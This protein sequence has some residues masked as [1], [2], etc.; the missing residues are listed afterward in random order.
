MRITGLFATL[1]LAVLVVLAACSDNDNPAGA[2]SS[3]TP[4]T[5]NEGGG[6]VDPSEAG[7]GDGG[8]VSNTSVCS[9]TKPSANKD[10]GRVFKGT[11]LLPEK[12]LDGEL[13]I[14]RFGKIVCADKS[15]ATVPVQL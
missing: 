12:A 11:L 9:T 7:T 15:C 6:P 14:D 5:E 3:G 8:P 4:D 2:G 10:A 13:F 1:P